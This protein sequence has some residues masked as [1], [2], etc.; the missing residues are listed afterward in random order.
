MTEMVPVHRDRRGAWDSHQ[1]EL[2]APAFAA[3]REAAALRPDR[4]E[5]PLQAP[6]VVRD[7]DGHA[8]QL[9]QQ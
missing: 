1:P 9:V 8:I 2:P 6:I 3:T 5:G 4:E 7:P